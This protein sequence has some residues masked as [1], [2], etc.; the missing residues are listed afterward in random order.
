MRLASRTKRAHERITALLQAADPALDPDLASHRAAVVLEADPLGLKLVAG[1]AGEIKTGQLLFFRTAD[2]DA[3]AAVAT[4]YAADVDAVPSSI[5]NPLLEGKKATGKGTLP[6]E[7]IKAV[8]TAMTSPSDAV[9]VALFGRMVAELPEANVDA[10]CQVAH[11]MGVH[12]LVAEDDFF[13]A[14][15]DLQPQ[16]TA[17]ADMIG[18][19]S[20]NASCL[21]RYA[22]LDV[23]GLVANLGADGPGDDAV[24]T[25]IAAFTRAFVSSI[26]SGKQNTFAANNPP[27]S[28]LVT[29]RRRG[30]WN[31]SNAFVEPVNA[32]A[33][34][35]A[36]DAVATD[37][38]LGHFAELQTM[39]GRADQPVTGVL[40]SRVAGG[41]L[42]AGVRQV[43]SLGDVI[44][45]LS[46]VA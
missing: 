24:V 46:S 11:A 1:D 19:V 8:K 14:V 6:K 17:G 35:G 7:A 38:L 31:L 13:T 29:Q 27:S 39:Y 2:I 28:V 42:P 44:D 15:D 12:R 36:V 22:A 41:A 45:A 21:Y 25:A 4:A 33:D 40:L 30:A 26:P 34:A 20:Y 3:L 32:G 16:D 43:A 9:D 23:D 18:L 10:C 5:G 37:R